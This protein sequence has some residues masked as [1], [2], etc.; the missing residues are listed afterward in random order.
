MLYGKQ[1]E[2]LSTNLMTAESL[3]DNGISTEGN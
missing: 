3:I 1:D 2:K